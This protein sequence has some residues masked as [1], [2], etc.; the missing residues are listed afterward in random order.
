[1]QA[2]SQSPPRDVPSA[3]NLAGGAGRSMPEEGHA[4]GKSLSEKVAHTSGGSTS[5]N[6]VTASSAD[7]SAHV[8]R[9]PLHLQQPATSIK[10]HNTDQFVAPMSPGAL[11]TQKSRRQPASDVANRVPPSE[12]DD[13]RPASRSRAASAASALVR[14][15]NQ[16]VSTDPDEPIEHEWHRGN[17][18]FARSAA[19]FGCSERRVVAPRYQL[20]SSKCFAAPVYH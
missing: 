17:Q 2:I 1:M 7:S 6:V 8:F 14:L 3:R 11:G 18:Q 4:S 16:S 12:G 20:Q 10:N 19:Q 9:M 5:A 15:H 13:S